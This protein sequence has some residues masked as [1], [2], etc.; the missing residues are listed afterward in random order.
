MAVLKNKYKKAG[1]KAVRGAGEMAQW[2]GAFA[3][4]VGRTGV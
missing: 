4:L 1:K 2:L 3:A